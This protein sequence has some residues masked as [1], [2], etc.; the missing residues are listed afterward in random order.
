MQFHLIK[1]FD[2]VKK[3]MDSNAISLS[4]RVYRKILNV[5]VYS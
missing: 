1:G 5:R 4:I 2:W 3:I